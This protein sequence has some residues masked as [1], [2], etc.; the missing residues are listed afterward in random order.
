MLESFRISSGAVLYKDAIVIQLD[1]DGVSAFG[2][3][4]PMAGSFYSDETPELCWLELNSVAPLIFNFRE[5]DMRRINEKLDSLNISCFSK[6]GIE[7]AFWDLLSRLE[8]LPIFQLLGAKERKIESGLAVGIYDDRRKFLEVI[9]KNLACGYKRVKIKIQPGWDLE[10]I[11]LVRETFGDI[12][13][14]VDANCAYSRR[15]M[16]HL[17]KFD[18]FALIMIEQPLAKDDLEGHAILQSKLRTPICLDESATTPGGVKRAIEMGSCKI[19]NIK[20]QRVGGIL[21]ALEIYNICGDKVSVWAGTM[22]ELGIGSVHTL[23]LAML[24]KFKFPTDVESSDRWFIDDIV[25]PIIKVENGEISAPEKLSY[26]VDVEKIRRYT[27]RE[28]Y[29]GSFR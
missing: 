5:L 17:R 29:F 19:I 22:P 23:H 25:D 18:D 14:M 7:T 10:P 3:A 24:D 2:E 8:G 1:A 21:S 27:I 15:D 11:R 4:S 13:L 26:E 16:E 28:R 20:I 9:D 12:P 6:A